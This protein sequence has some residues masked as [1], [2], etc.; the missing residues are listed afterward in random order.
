MD[1]S[2]SFFDKMSAERIPLCAHFYTETKKQPSEILQILCKNQFTGFFCFG[3]GW[4]K[5]RYPYL[6][7]S[8]PF[9]PLY[10]SVS[11]R[12]AVH[13]CKTQVPPAHFIRRGGYYNG[14]IP[15]SGS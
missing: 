11:F 13:R 8:F 14:G 5:G 12:G 4:D 10:I 6:F 1:F 3:S 7:S 15:L 9:F 2:G